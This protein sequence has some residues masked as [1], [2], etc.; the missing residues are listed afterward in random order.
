MLPH[1]EIIDQLD[2]SGAIIG[3]V[4]RTALLATGSKNYR[5]ASALFRTREGDFIMF[6]RAYSKKVFPGLFGAVGGIAQT[7]E[8]YEE[9]FARE[10]L[11]EVGLNVHDYPWKLIGYTT[12]QHDNTFGHVG[13]Y[14]I[15]CDSI[16]AYNKD[17]FAEYRIFSFE[18]LAALCAENKE[19]THNMPIEFKKFYLHT[20]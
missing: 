13:L 17:D 9:A 15:T 1:D 14:E 16:N 20:K 12:P 6:R 2:D 19:V 4:S 5:L 10:V 18:E 8:T 3:P 11:E 7:G